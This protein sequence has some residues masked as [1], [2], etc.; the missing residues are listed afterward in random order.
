[1]F[2]KDGS[3]AAWE[4]V[5][6]MGINTGTLP[7]LANATFPVLCMGPPHLGSALDHLQLEAMQSTY[8][9]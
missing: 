1:M 2:G 7:L 5:G 9:L 8:S 3:A 4:G 6:G